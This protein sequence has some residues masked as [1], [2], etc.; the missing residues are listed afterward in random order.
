MGKLFNIFTGQHCKMAN[1]VCIASTM[2]GVVECLI[3]GYKVIKISINLK[4]GLDLEV[5]L[6]T[7]GTGAAGSFSLNVYGPRI[8][9]RLIF[10]KLKGILN[11]DFS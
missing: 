5:M 10:D 7:I 6:N 8:L 1:Q 11:L 3:Y 4:A 9:K 2:M